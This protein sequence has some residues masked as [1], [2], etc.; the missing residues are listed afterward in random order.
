MARPTDFTRIINTFKT[1]S[2]LKSFIGLNLVAGR[3]VGVTEAQSF[4]F[5]FKLYRLWLVLTSV[6]GGRPSDRRPAKVLLR[7][8][9]APKFVVLSTSLK[10]SGEMRACWVSN[11]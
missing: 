3:K 9:H 11:P 8:W 2:Y 4:G 6:E 10:Q 1:E 5:H 7:G